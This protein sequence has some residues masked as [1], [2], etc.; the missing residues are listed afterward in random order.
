[1]QQIHARVSEEFKR[2]VDLECVSRGISQQEC[3]EKALRLFLNGKRERRSV[4]IPREAR[5]WE[6]IWRRYWSTMPDGKISIMVHAMKFDL[7]H[8]KSSR[9]KQR[10]P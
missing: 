9:H 4:L 3:I 7:V 8:Y 5:T 6:S 10:Q 2:E 1:M